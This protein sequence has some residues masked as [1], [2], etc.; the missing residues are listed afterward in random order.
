MLKLRQ[1][2]KDKGIR[3]GIGAEDQM[4]IQF[5]LL[6]QKYEFYKKMPSVIRWTYIASG[7][8]RTASTAGMLKK[9]G[10]KS[11]FPDY[12]FFIY[13]KRTLL[14]NIIFF[15]FKTEKG[16]QQKS[17][18]DFELAFAG[19]PNVQYYLV[20][21]VEQAVKILEEKEVLITA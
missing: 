5:G 18:V 2:R 10:V 11:G 16:E 8:K 19:A 17:Q 14:V 7:E 20:R 13:D 15:E 4:H 1:P 6:M 3:R 21:S 9:K 12:Q